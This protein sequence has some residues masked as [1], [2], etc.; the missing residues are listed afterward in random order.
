MQSLQNVYSIGTPF[1]GTTLASAPNTGLNSNLSPENT[2]SFELDLKIS[3]L[4]TN[5][6]DLTFMTL[7]Q[8]TKFWL[9]DHLL[10]LVLFV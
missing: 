4:T 5:W 2:T 3:F 10:L 9:L 6:F 8:T 1:A 7:Q